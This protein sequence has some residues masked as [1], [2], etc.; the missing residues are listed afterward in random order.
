MT[1]E[2]LKKLSS[3]GYVCGYCG[4]DISSNVGFRGKDEDGFRTC[5][6]ICHRCDMPT[7]FDGK[8]H[9]QVPGFPYGN[10]VDHVPPEVDSLYNEARHCT[11]VKAYTASVLCSRKLLMNI[12]V[13]KGADKGLNFIQYVEYLSDKGF[14]PP[15]GKEWVDHIRKKGNEATHEIPI[16]KRE[17]AEHLI[18]FIEMLLK[19]IFEFTAIIKRKKSDDAA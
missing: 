3:K 7:F 15:D 18:N 2:D 6:Y 8:G 16:M 17:D 5:I 19:F 11:S 9:Y 1:W 14:V 4:K 13:S 10:K 12:G